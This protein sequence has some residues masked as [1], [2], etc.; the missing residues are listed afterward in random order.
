MKLPFAAHQQPFLSLA[1]TQAK[2]RT[3]YLN[4]LQLSGKYAL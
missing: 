1:P 2:Q 3:I 4:N